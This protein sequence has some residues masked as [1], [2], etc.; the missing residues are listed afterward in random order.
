MTFCEEC[1]TALEARQY[2]CTGCGAENSHVQETLHPTSVNPPPGYLLEGELGSGAAGTVYLGRQLSLDRLVALK[3]VPVQASDSAIAIYGAEARTL[4]ALNN[5]AIVA[6]YD[7]LVSDG[8]VWLVM[9]LVNGLD[10]QS[11]LDSENEITTDQALAVLNGVAHALTAAHSCGYIHR[12]IKPANIL[13]GR[14]GK[15]HLTDFGIATLQRSTDGQADQL[16]G[17]PAYMSPEQTTGMNVTIASDTYSLGLVAYT[18]LYSTN[19]YAE[20]ASSFPKDMG[21]HEMQSRILAAQRE[22]P[23]PSP[24]ADTPKERAKLFS[25]IQKATAKEPSE[26]YGSVEEFI[27]ALNKSADYEAG[28]NPTEKWVRD[29]KSGKGARPKRSAFSLA[30]ICLLSAAIGAGV[31]FLIKAVS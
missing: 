26:R 21:P 8:A 27:T 2:F 13:V 30:L 17:T 31:F 7:V 20:L 10:L 12:D 11:L 1:G 28:L 16:A 22:D 9:Q 3:R 19:P 29:L 4:A 6:V 18:L 5:P 15:S 24:P 25:V 14:N 23:L